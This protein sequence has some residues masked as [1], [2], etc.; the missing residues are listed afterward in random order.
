MTSSIEISLFNPKLTYTAGDVLRGQVIL[1]ARQDE[2][3]GSV[4]ITF[5]GRSK[6]K[7][8]RSNGE[9]R[10]VFRGR[11]GLFSF[12]K[13]LYSG[14]HYTVRADEYKWDFEFTIP[15]SNDMSC[16]G[17][18]FKSRG[19]FRPSTEQHP[20]PPSFHRYGYDARN[21]GMVEYKLAAVMVRHTKV[22]K[23]ESALDIP[24]LPPD[25]VP[26]PD[27]GL[28]SSEQHYQARTLKLL[29][30]K[31]KLTF[32]EKLHT[33]FGGD[34]PHATFRIR[35]IYPTVTWTG[36]ALP[37]QLA[38]VAMDTSQDIPEYPVVLLTGMTVKIR[39]RILFRASS[40]RIETNGQLNEEHTLQNVSHMLGPIPY[41]KI[42]KTEPGQPTGTG[43]II[44]LPEPGKYLDLSQFRSGGFRTPNMTPS[45][46]TMNIVVMHHMK[47]KL[48]FNCAGK[49]F[50]MEHVDSL[51]VH[52][53]PTGPM[54]VA[55]TAAA[56]A[57]HSQGNPPELPVYSQDVPKGTKILEA[58]APA[59]PP[60]Y[61]AGS[62]SGGNPK[63]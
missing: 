29:P 43:R 34:V 19:G 45:F 31:Q 12:T 10:T 46:R 35:L 61:A 18:K 33:F 39:T 15:S 1:Q 56:T 37:F 59:A 2:N 11:A 23:L 17:D 27:L 55:Q 52:S 21:Q 32:R 41:A 51:L 20:L 4:A 7:L 53:P 40:W 42:D 47:V 28:I 26:K 62:S 5:Y 30:D 3:I 8:V 38:I 6:T 13:T 24:Y 50:S 54:P 63:S 14:G 9:N 57:T 25:P 36:R 44:G 48:Q 60:Q 49:K 22:S 58:G 16:H